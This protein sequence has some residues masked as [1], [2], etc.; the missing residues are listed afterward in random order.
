[1]ASH[2]AAQGEAMA[3]LIFLGYPLHP[4]NQPH[5]LRT[6]HWA[7]ISC[8]MLFVQGSRDALCQLDLL[9]QAMHTLMVPPT[10]H[11]IAQADHSFLVP[12]SQRRSSQEVWQEL[13]QVTVH[14]LQA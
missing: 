2:L 13:V 4:A 8:P 6:A 14:W 1:M 7:Q 10:L 5:K 3:G 9:R 12:K 11:V